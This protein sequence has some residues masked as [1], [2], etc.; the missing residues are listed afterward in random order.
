LNIGKSFWQDQEL[1]PDSISY[2]RQFVPFLGKSFIET[3]VLQ[4]WTRRKQFSLLRIGTMK[5]TRQF[6]KAQFC[7]KAQQ[8]THGLTLPTSMVRAPGLLLIYSTL[9]L[10]FQLLLWARL[11][12][13]FIA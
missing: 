2:L 13:K 4:S 6:H 7:F 10:M 9:C 3:V 11:M 12:A 5:A 1:S 8:H